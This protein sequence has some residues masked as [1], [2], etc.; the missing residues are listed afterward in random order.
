MTLKSKNKKYFEGLLCKG[1]L[2]ANVFRRMDHSAL[3]LFQ[4]ADGAIRPDRPP[5]GLDY[6]VVDT[7][8]TS[9]MRRTNS[10]LC[11]GGMIHSFTR[12]GLISFF[13]HDAN[14]G[15][16]NLV[17][18]A[19]FDYSVRDALQLPAALAFGRF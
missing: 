13:L 1:S 19:Q 10:A 12:Q 11:M 4:G 8:S 14:A 5:G 3:G 6:R 7:L 18:H 2:P 15:G 9:S 17:N 16:A